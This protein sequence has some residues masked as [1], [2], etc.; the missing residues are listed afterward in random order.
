MTEGQGGFMNI[1]A[2][3]LTKNEEKNIV[4]CLDALKWCNEIIVIDDHSGDET[5]SLA[6]KLGANVYTHSLENN[7]AQQRNFGLSKATREWVLFVDADERV[8][9]E[10]SK[11]I[12]SRITNHESIRQ[13]QD[14][15]SIEGSRINGFYIRRLDNLWGR[16]LNHGETGNI[17]FVRL[18]K[19]NAGQWKGKVHERWE[20]SGKIGEL[21][22][23]LM[24]YPHQTLAE[25]LQEINFYTTLRAKELYQQN[26]QVHFWDIILYPKAKFIQ[27]YLLKRGF[28]D[29]TAGIVFALCMSFHS[30]LVRAKLWQ[31]WQKK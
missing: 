13:A 24:H 29:G 20:I 22:Q 19:K 25:F 9:P 14:P 5:V 31:L 27:N 8:S 23:P 17:K 1:A 4:S 21:K 15:E 30:F 12:E 2:I 7:F 16:I 28:L 3:I 18:A 10:L 11:E 6:K 26:V